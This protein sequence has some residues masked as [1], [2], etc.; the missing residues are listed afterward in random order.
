MRQLP[1][2]ARIVLSGARLAVVNWNMK[3]NIESFPMCGALF[4]FYNLE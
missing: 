4:Y 1:A 2:S 3:E